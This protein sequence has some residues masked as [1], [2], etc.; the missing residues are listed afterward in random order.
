M[1]VDASALLAIV[2]SEP[3]QEAFAT[4]LF[5]NRDSLNISPINMWEVTTRVEVLSDMDVKRRWEDTTSMFDFRL[6][7]I[8]VPILELAIDAH[9]RFGRGRHRAGLNMGDCF[10]YA[11]AMSRGE[12]LLFKGDDFIHTDVKRAL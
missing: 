6:C 7:V 3:E 10:A 2:L 9:R 11:L 4:L 12:P 1:I 5:E 8:G